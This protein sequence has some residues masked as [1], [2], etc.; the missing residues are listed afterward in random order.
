MICVGSI[1]LCLAAWFSAATASVPSP[2]GAAPEPI[3]AQVILHALQQRSAAVTSWHYSYELD[4]DAIHQRKM[5]GAVFPDVYYH[6][7]AKSTLLYHYD[8]D[9]FGQRIVI[10]G[11]HAVAEF[12]AQRVFR[13]VQVASDGA[14]PGTSG[15]DLLLYFVPSWPPRQLKPPRAS[16]G[17]PVISSQLTDADLASTTASVQ[18]IGGRHCHMLLLNGGDRIYVDMARGAAVVARDLAEKPGGDPVLRLE[19]VAQRRSADGDWIPTDFRLFRIA[20]PER[21]ERVKLPLQGRLLEVAFNPGSSKVLPSAVDVPGAIR[22]S[23]DGYEQVVPDGHGHADATAALISAGIRRRSSKWPIVTD[24]LPAWPLILAAVLVPLL[25]VAARSSTRTWPGRQ[26]F[27]SPRHNLRLKNK[28]KAGFTLVELIVVLGII[29]VLAAI[30]L[31]TLAHARRKARTLSC[32]SN[33]RQVVASMALYANDNQGYV[34]RDSG[35]FKDHS[36]R[37]YWGFLVL[38][39]LRGE[40][41]LRLAPPEEYM[42]APL[43]KLLQCPAHPLGSEIPS[44]YFINAFAFE[45]QPDWY[46]AGPT[47]LASVSDATQVVLFAEVVDQTIRHINEPPGDWIYLLRVQ[48]VWR[49]GHLPNGDEPRI[50]EL[51]H[52]GGANQAF[53]DAHVEWRPSPKMRL[54]H[55]DDGIRLNRKAPEGFWGE[56]L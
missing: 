39:Y 11:H 5:I 2:V 7:A 44:C 21:G 14:M 42:K 41:E 4:Y 1:I 17:D 30:I 31:P 40:D 8:G 3:P 55:F 20:P 49:P 19:V 12:P 16:S 10:R 56:G 13:D 29:A 37:D 43:S 47:R 48:D 45:T 15:G 35:H 24:L 22:I 53:F 28:R 38:P 18:L 9:P 52:G 46:P 36:L 54:S 25:V 51:R 6:S 27:L 23:N 32:A 26:S 33:L 34:P 50:T